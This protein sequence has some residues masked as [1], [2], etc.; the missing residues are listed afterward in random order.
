MFET[1]SALAV[2]DGCIGASLD[3]KSHCFDMRRPAISQNHRLKQRGLAKIVDM[4]E[5]G[6][7]ENQ[8]LNHLVMAEMSRCDECRA[9]VRTRDIVCIGPD[10]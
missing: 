7:A 8:A 9:F 10:R 6:A 1:S 2:C 4:I 3:Q 5:R